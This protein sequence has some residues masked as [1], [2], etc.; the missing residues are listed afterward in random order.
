MRNNFLKI[1][2]LVPEKLHHTVWRDESRDTFVLTKFREIHRVDEESMRMIC[3]SR[4]IFKQILKSKLVYNQ[5][6]TDDGLH[7]AEFKNANLPKIMNYGIHFRRPN[8]NSKWIL[9]KK[10]RLAHEI[11]PYDG[12]RQSSQ[13]YNSKFYQ[14]LDPKIKSRLFAHIKLDKNLHSEQ[15]ELNF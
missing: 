13:D 4:T 3:W 8:K 12:Q 11:R 7:M 6:Y 15:I 10:E 1:S 9:D 2:K 5:D 14:K